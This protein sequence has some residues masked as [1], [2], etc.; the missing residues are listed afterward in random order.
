MPD[1][2]F[3]LP[4]PDLTLTNYT[5]FK[6]TSVSKIHV[7][8]ILVMHCLHTAPRYTYSFGYKNDPTDGETIGQYILLS[9]ATLNGKREGGGKTPVLL[10]YTVFYSP[11]LSVSAGDPKLLF[12]KSGSDFIFA[13][14]LAPAYFLNIHF[15]NLT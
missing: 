6:G 14:S 3:A 9:V 7:K 15:L 12:F 4:I 5:Y 1:P 13:P 8:P 11:L 2:G 10:A